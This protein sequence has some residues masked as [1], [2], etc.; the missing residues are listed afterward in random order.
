MQH[1]FR[2]CAVCEVLWTRFAVT[3]ALPFGPIGGGTEEA[4]S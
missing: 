4:G 2:N 3:E 1:S